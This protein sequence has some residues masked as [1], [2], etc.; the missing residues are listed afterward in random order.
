M[1]TTI[2]SLRSQVKVLLGYHPRVVHE[3]GTETPEGYDISTVEP[4]DARVA[5]K[6]VFAQ[7]NALQK[8]VEKERPYSRVFQYVPSSDLFATAA[9]DGQLDWSG[10]R[11]A[12]DGFD[13]KNDSMQSTQRAVKEGDY[14]S[15]WLRGTV[16]SPPTPL[17]ATRAI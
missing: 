12:N 7:G 9:S 5:G 13:Y 15:L 10:N 4:S 17:R 3:D 16:A 2:N 1:E 8:R 11:M 6:N 14:L